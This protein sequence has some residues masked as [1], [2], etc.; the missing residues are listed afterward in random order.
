MVGQVVP[1]SHRDSAMVS[2][3]ANTEPPFEHIYWLA[4]GK[5]DLSQ[6]GDKCWQ[7]RISGLTGVK[8]SR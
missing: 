2:V 7:L 3:F 6:C 5:L 8:I 4:L 1:L